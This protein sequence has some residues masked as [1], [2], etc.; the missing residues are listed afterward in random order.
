MR[1]DEGW[2]PPLLSPSAAH[3]CAMP[4]SAPCP[5]ASNAYLCGQVVGGHHPYFVHVAKASAAC[6]PP[7]L[8]IGGNQGTAASAASLE[9]WEAAARGRAIGDREQINQHAIIP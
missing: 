7:G 2:L 6:A 8:L 3:A 4:W 9:E 1:K 5:V